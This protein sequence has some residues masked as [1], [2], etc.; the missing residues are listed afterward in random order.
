VVLIEG[1]HVGILSPTHLIILSTCCAPVVILVVVLVLLLSRGRP[2]PTVVVVPGPA[3]APG[4]YTDPTHRH[5]FRYW[6]GQTWTSEVSDSGVTGQ[7][8]LS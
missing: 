8:P 2:S 1:E 6:N 5:E 7:D 3:S 4:W